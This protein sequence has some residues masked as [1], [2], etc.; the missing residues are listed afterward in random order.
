MSHL[1]CDLSLQLV[2]ALWALHTHGPH[3]YRLVPDP[4]GINRNVRAEQIEELRLVGV[5]VCVQV[6][7]WGCAFLGRFTAALP[8]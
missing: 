1:L 7:A 5:H 4:G 8:K 6:C 2:S 3:T